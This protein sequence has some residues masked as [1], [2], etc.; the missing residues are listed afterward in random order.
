MTNRIFEI[1]RYFWTGVVCLL[2]A[3]ASA[4]TAR[5]LDPNKKL[6]QYVH[7]TWQT[8]EG[9]SQT[10][11]Y[12]VT[13]THDGHL[14][15]GTQSGVLRF[16]GVEFSP[17]R[18]LQSN[19]LGDIWARSMLEDGGGHLW[20]VTND[21]QLIR[22]SGSKVKVFSEEDG[23]PT[24]Y[25]SCL[26]R[27]EGDE[28]WAC[29]PTGL[30]RFQ[31]D[32]FEVHE[33]PE[34]ISRRPNTG[35]RGSD[36]KIWM[37]GGDLL[38][39]WDGS[40][41]SRVAL[42]SVSGDLQ[43]R[44]LLCSGDDVWIG[45][46]KGLVRYTGG[47]EKLYTPK[48]GLSDEGVLAL[49]PGRDGTVW[50]GTR[51]GF[52]RVR[53][54]SVE[55]Y[56]Y[57]DGLSQNTVYW[58]YEDREG[59]LWVATKNGLN[60]FL[61]GAATRYGRSE[62]LPSNNPGPVF[63]DRRG[64]LWAGSI[65]G[66]LSRFSDTAFVPLRAFA[67]R[68]V[69]VLAED[70]NGDLWAGSNSGA[71]RLRDGEIKEVYTT[72]QGLPADQIRCMFRDR[73]GELWVGTEKGLAVF[74]GGRFVQI[75]ALQPELSV[76]ISAIGETREGVMLFAAARGSLYRYA[77][78]TLKKVEQIPN[79]LTLVQD[80]NAIYTDPDGIV[81]M[82]M[83]GLGLGMLH[84]GKLIRIRV[85]DGL[86]DGE[87]YGFVLDAQD[88][89]WMAC[90]KGFFWVD[91]KDLL[92]FADGKIAKVSSTPYSP[93]DGLRTIQGTPDVQPVGV[94]SADGHLWF[95]ATVRL[96]AFA[97][98][99]GIRPGSIPPVVVENVIIDGNAVDP[100]DVKTLGPGRTNVEFEYSALTYLSP[101]RVNF[102]YMLEGY[103]RGW[104]NAGSRHAAFYTNLPPGKFRFR[105]VAC[106]AFINCNEAGSTFDF[107][108]AP[109]FY[110]RLWFLPLCLA[111]IGLLVW[112]AYRFRVEQLRGRFTL[113]LA[114]RSR[115]ARELHDTLIQGFSGI[116]MQLHA[117]TNRL[118][119]SEDRNTLEEIIRDAGICL[120]E[121][122]RSV[123][124]LRGGTGSSSGLSTA[125]A[126]AARQ[127]VQEHDVK[128]KL[129]LDARRQE[130]P[131]EVK[132]NLL[133]IV[134]EAITNSIKHSGART[135]EVS[136]A[137]SANDL[138][139]SVRD[140]GRGL[141]RPDGNGRAGH[142]GMIGMKERASQIGAEME[143][144]STP[145]RGTKV[146]VRVPVAQGPLTSPQG[147]LEPI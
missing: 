83:N 31:G 65:D 43:M 108:V 91:R 142:F 68:P 120:Q 90:G 125:V 99:L 71:F 96:L 22:I 93:L 2:L 76:P 20:I 136:L 44:T 1:M 69:S 38:T 84:D 55:S 12:S 133:C 54:G 17:I 40:Q 139:L 42:K 41:F 45:T 8:P 51:N 144:A 87:I 4:G 131:A 21:Y 16:D 10:S 27:G 81:W 28:V 110:Q 113:V 112:L 63:Q 146:S 62:G 73:A 72:A 77:E 47:R 121:T 29:T 13:Q 134:Q 135:I 98:G 101:Q 74:R 122:R 5:A 70:G 9:L 115:I 36:G 147:R 130:L 145:G 129:N 92:K 141:S 94:R 32:K 60:Q 78:G 117:F 23:L 66:G 103:D 82:G 7:R 106:G 111:A 124:G 33:S 79:V 100:A 67:G 86:F 37:A 102:R 126:D 88:R 80:I 114:E 49:A 119:G 89:L 118:T 25:F 39:T 11:V 50:V 3:L 26:V 48:D 140:D 30:V 104:T 58:V 14:V 123:A 18:A 64:N 107:E 19:S 105:V 127:L 95:S 35:C 56:G 137:C 61:E 34:Q 57:R 53:K 15:I 132:Y 116:T 52:S 59:S 46:G 143:V 85:R 75:A 6:T 109:F 128:L 97:P 138:R 24:Q